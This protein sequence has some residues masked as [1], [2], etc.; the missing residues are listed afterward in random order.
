MKTK[1]TFVRK[2]LVALFGYD[3]AKSTVTGRPS[4]RNKGK[5]APVKHLEPKKVRAIK[6]IYKYFLIKVLGIDPHEAE[7]EADKTN[8]LISKKVAQIKRQHE[9]PVKDG[10]IVLGNVKVDVDT[11][12][13]LQEIDNEFNNELDNVVME[14]IQVEQLDELGMEKGNPLQEPLEIQDVMHT[15]YENVVFQPEGDFDGQDT[16]SHSE[17]EVAGALKAAPDTLNAPGPSEATHIFPPTLGNVQDT[18][19]DY[20]TILKDVMNGSMASDNYIDTDSEL[21]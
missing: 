11:T 18:S 13:H 14:E 16:S 1:N 15:S 2:M 20:N 19:K 7:M 9:K 10:R 6:D 3:L 21:D 5:Q 4:N 17:H 12:E 8:L